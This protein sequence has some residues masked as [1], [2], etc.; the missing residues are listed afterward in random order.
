MHFLRRLA[1]RNA[2][3][4]FPGLLTSRP[5]SGMFFLLAS[6]ATVPFIGLV[7]LVAALSANLT[8]YWTYRERIRWD[9]GLAGTHAVMLGLTFGY[10]LPFHLVVLVASRRRVRFQRS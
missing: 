5:L 7:G 8:G 10:F 2:R 3:I 9:L 4:L 1:R 6:F